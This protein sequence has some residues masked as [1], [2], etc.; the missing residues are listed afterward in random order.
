[1]MTKLATAILVAG[2]MLPGASFAAG[3]YASGASNPQAD[4]TK[5]D[6]KA[7][8]PATTAR[9]ATDKAKDNVSDAA[10]TTKVKAKFAADN[11]VSAMNIKVDT[12]NGV[13][14]L[15]GNAKSQD[16][17]AK[18][19]EIARGTEGVTSVTNDIRVS[20]AK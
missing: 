16:E 15:S 6:T 19:A 14:K 9:S 1:M 3:N 7:G 10:I 20:A 8:A 4:A 17:A 13:V 12:D 5:A 18:A 2:M 11:Q